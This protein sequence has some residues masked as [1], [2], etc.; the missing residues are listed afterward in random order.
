MGIF[1]KK[2]L[3]FLSASCHQ[4]QFWQCRFICGMLFLIASTQ[5][6][7]YA[8]DPI[9]K[10]LREFELT[11][12]ALEKEASMSQ[13]QLSSFFYSLYR[14]ET[15]KRSTP[16]RILH[17]GDSHIVADLFSGDLRE[18][19]QNR[20]D[21]AGRGFLPPGI[22]DKYYHARGIKVSQYGDWKKYSVYKN[23][24]IPYGI[25]GVKFSSRNKKSKMMLET[26]YPFDYSEVGF[27]TSPES[28][29]VVIHIGQHKEI[30]DTKGNENQIRYFKSYKKG[31]RLTVSPH[32]DG[33]VTLL[34]W[35]VENTRPG[36]IYTNIGHTGV[37]ADIMS[38]WDKD[39]IARDIKALKPDLIV[40]SYGTNE[41]FF[42]NLNIKRY[43][44]KYVNSIKVL[45]KYAPNASFLIIGAPGAVRFP[46]YISS[47][48]KKAIGNC[49]ELKKQEIQNYKKLL[50]KKDKKLA[51]WHP[52]PN[53]NK[54][55]F[56]QESIAK[57]IGA[58][59]WDWSAIMQGDC[60]IISWSQQKPAFAYSDFV[61]MTHKGARY[62]ARLL[63]Y[64]IMYFY[65]RE[66]GV[67]RN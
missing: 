62:S 48:R 10:L 1:F 14:L 47:G 66:K 53:L 9:A 40:L 30:F 43:R 42:D 3:C 13:H 27:Q 51:F 16:V 41:G 38:R 56:V 31:K 24:K 4:S 36:I 63:F 58:W 26:K 52:P 39:F 19:F 28:G 37:S 61:H 17:L 60:G 45:K 59:F 54:V 33:K 7:V 64:D 18:F 34:S 20:F 11:Q 5:D 46:R 12:N 23:K 22:P 57:E 15:K 44:D 8:K 67:F 49:R 65:N 29:H 50:Y 55:R 21:S 25:S 6:I 35:R 32:G 2:L